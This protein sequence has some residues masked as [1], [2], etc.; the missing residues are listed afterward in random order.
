[1]ENIILEVSMPHFQL[2]CPKQHGSIHAA[3]ELQFS[4]LFIEDKL[5]CEC[6]HF[7]LVVKTS[8][9]SIGATGRRVT[10]VVNVPSQWD[11]M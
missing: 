5:K 4:V 1:M 10:V 2:I 9:G 7:F 8:K 6:S 3:V 11:L